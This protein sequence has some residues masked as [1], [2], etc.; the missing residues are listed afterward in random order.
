MWTLYCEAYSDLLV[1]SKYIN[2]NLNYICVFFVFLYL[3]WRLISSHRHDQIKVC[4]Q[5]QSDDL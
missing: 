2:I 5:Q 1:I 4:L 3:I